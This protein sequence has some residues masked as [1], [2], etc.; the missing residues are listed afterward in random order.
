MSDEAN[1]PKPLP[2]GVMRSSEIAKESFARVLLLGAAKLGKTT[3]LLET[4][5]KPLVI[6]CDGEGATQYAAS[7]GA[8][9]LEMKVGNVDGVGCVKAWTA[10]R[11]T[12]KQLV[13]AGEVKTIIIDTI[14]LLAVNLKEDLDASGKDGFELWNEMFAQIVGGYKRLAELGAH[15]VVVGHMD[16]REDE[17][18]G[19]MPLIPGKSQAILPALTADWVLFDYE[20]GRK[21]ERAFLLGPQKTWTHS[22]RNI[23]KTAIV[24]PDFCKL[25]ETLGFEP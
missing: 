15:L 9:F 22:G 3:C 16:P 21:P 7:G 24:E 13:E 23:K 8:D 25:L 17:I 10:A 18:S 11:R 20:A 1:T 4:A 6:N 2:A 12:A 19:I 5:P 14:S